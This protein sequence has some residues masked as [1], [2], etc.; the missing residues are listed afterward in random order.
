[1]NV[2]IGKLIFPPV[3]CFSGICSLVSVTTF[4][5]VA[6][7][8]GWLP[9]PD[10]NFL[11]WSFGLAVIATFLKF[12]TAVLF[13]IESQII[14]H[15]RDK[16]L[17]QRSNVFTLSSDDPPYQQTKAWRKALR[18]ELVFLQKETPAFIF[19]NGMSFYSRVF[20]LHAVELNWSSAPFII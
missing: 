2:K 1:M 8:A 15:R 9:D 4:G 6:D 7:S 16:L 3:F 5:A 14:K 13:Y 17:G 18:N 19:T 11:S 20:F 12:V 10:H